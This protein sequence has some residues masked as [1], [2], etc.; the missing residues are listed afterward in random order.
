MLKATVVDTP[1]GRVVIMD[2]IT[3]VTPDDAGQHVV[4]ASHGGASSGEFA[5]EVPLGSVFFNDAGVGKDNAGIAALDMLQKRGVAA[6]AVAHTSGRIGDSM[7]MWE[8]GVLSHVNA[9]GKA[10]GLAPGARVRTVLTQ[11]VSR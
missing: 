3:K 9:V 7:D 4:S 5:L 8:N 10:A 2:S 6:A 1:K 11:L